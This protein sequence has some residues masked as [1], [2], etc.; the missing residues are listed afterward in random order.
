M[1]YV[2]KTDTIFNQIRNKVDEMFQ[3][4][5]NHA[6]DWTNYGLDKEEIN[7]LCWE[8]L[9]SNEQLELMKV[10]GSKFFDTKTQG[11][12]TVQIALAES[13]QNTARYEL[14]YDKKYYMIPGH[15]ENR[16]GRTAELI[17][18]NDRLRELAS[19]RAAQ[20]SAIESEKG[21]FVGSIKAVWSKAPSVN[22]FV[23]LW[24]AGLDL[25]P[26]DVRDEL[27]RPSERTKTSDLGIDKDDIG[28][29]N[30]NLLR[31]KVA[32]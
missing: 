30:A 15:W 5:L 18:Q 17:I 3:G 24:P 25:L 10:L 12:L 27:Q 4:R 14:P 7:R 11:T 29:L 32:V 8:T 13:T 6:H 1:A 28:A 22:S 16:Y 2:R 26:Y 23:K 21:E 31:A 19:K 9:I 20:L